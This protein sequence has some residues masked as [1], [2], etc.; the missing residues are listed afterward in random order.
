MDH[1]TVNLRGRSLTLMDV[2]NTLCEFGKYVKETKNPRKK[3][4]YRPS[5]P[6]VQ[7]VPIVPAWW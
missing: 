5:H 6:G 4:T 7:P 1:P 2:Q 3:T